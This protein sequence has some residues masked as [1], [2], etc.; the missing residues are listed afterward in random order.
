VTY[1]LRGSYTHGKHSADRCLPR[2]PRQLRS[3][4]MTIPRSCMPKMRPRQCCSSSPGCRSSQCGRTVASIAGDS[5]RYCQPGGVLV[6]RPDGVGVVETGV[7]GRGQS[8]AAAGAGDFDGEPFIGKRSTDFLDQARL[9]RRTAGSAVSFR[10][11]SFYRPAAATDAPGTTQT[12]HEAPTGQ[13]TPQGRPRSKHSADRT[14]P[15]DRRGS[16]RTVV[17]RGGKSAIAESHRGSPSVSD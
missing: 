11:I 7:A 5:P 2:Q 9:H 10:T 6:L 1:S 8:L 4:S 15:M 17:T 16:R 12:P 3:V 14:A 13:P